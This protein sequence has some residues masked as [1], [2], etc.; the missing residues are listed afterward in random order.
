MYKNSTNNN[1]NNK[2]SQK[3]VKLYICIG[4]LKLRISMIII[5]VL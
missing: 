1:K 4:K 3:F 2:N 5:K